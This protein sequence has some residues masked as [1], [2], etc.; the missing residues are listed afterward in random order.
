MARKSWE[1]PRIS[2]SDRGG[3]CAPPRLARRS[4]NRS[5][6]KQGTRHQCQRHES[7]YRSEPDPAHHLLDRETPYCESVERPETGVMPQ[8]R[9]KVASGDVV[10]VAMARRT[11]ATFCT[12]SVA[13][14]AAAQA[15][16]GVE[17]HTR[18]K[19]CDH[20]PFYRQSRISARGT[21]WSWSA[22]TLASP[23][24]RAPQHQRVHGYVVSPLALAASLE[25]HAE[26]GR[27][28]P[29]SPP[30]ATCGLRPRR[31]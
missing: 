23:V 10:R 6:A 8:M 14:S 9:D 1:S 4:G 12:V 11:P 28:I 17:P 21:G 26:R 15:A 18:T 7:D 27:R 20:L 22:P 29:T 16:A 19:Y 25:R 3:N 5:P 30:P 24:D 13:Q 2:S 31:A